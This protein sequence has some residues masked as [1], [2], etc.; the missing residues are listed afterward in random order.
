MPEIGTPPYSGYT[1]YR[2]LHKRLGRHLA[3][4]VS[5]DH[6]TSMA[7]A[8]YA[9]EPHL[10]RKLR[11]GCEAH[12]R[13]DDR[14]DDADLTNLEEKPK[15]AH[16]HDHEGK[17]QSRY[18]LIVCPGCGREFWI[19]YLSSIIGA[20]NRGAGTTYL[21]AM[22]PRTPPLHYSTEDQAIGYVYTSRV[23]D[24]EYLSPVE[25]R[26]HNPE[27]VSSNLTSATITLTEYHRRR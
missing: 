7:Y 22:R 23:F 18:V 6:R 13:N 24:A 17:R 10:G 19:Q 20:R 21:P 11:R 8:R 14:M 12:H 5:L 4:L 1:V 16:R 9:L 25:N 27:V 2:V 15:A 3:V 26:I